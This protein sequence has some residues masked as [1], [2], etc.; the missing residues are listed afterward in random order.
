MN[1]MRTKT[2]YS[3]GC[4]DLSDLEH[5]KYYEDLLAFIKYLGM[6]GTGK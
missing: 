6:I 4:Y 5:Y 1:A 3:L 2:K